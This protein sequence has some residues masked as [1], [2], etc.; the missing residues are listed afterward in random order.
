MTKRKPALIIVAGPNG[1]GKTTI[2]KE[3]LEHEWLTNAT[4]INADEIAQNQ[5]GDWNSYEAVRQAAELAD[6]LR[7]QYIAAGRD[8]AYET[9][10]ST[11]KRVDD[12]RKAKD[13]G[14]FVR[15]FFVATNDPQ[16]NVERVARRVSHGGHDV[17]TDRIIAR[18]HRSMQRARQALKLVD[19]GYV[20]DNS[21]TDRDYEFMFRTTSGI[22]AKV[23][24]DNMPTWARE[25]ANSV[26]PRPLPTNGYDPEPT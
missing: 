4:Y 7:H 3:L 23:Y 21:Q 1:S 22:I 5:F 20:I 16:I 24:Q 18:Y 10:F 11:D 19:R 9:V 8:F 14:Y 17:P 25:L 13:A 15:F 2:T 6:S 26:T 12:I